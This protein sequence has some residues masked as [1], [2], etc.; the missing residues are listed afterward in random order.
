LLAWVAFLPV[1]FVIEALSETSGGL[2]TFTPQ[3]VETYGQ[4]FLFVPILV[5]AAV[6]FSVVAYRQRKTDAQAN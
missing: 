5:A 3:F 2:I 1:A 6:A 4:E